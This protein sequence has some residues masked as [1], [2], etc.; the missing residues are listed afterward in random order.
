MYTSAA[1]RSASALNTDKES[2]RAAAGS[3]LNTGHRT[4]TDI[5]TGAGFLL[6]PIILKPAVEHGAEAQLIQLD[7][8]HSASTR[9]RRI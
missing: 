4:S 2:R 6:S 1:Y 5:A 9:N 8:L 7:E 3:E